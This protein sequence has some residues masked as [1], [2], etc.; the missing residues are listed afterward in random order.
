MLIMYVWDMLYR[1]GT[2]VLTS[3]NMS[4]HVWMSCPPTAWPTLIFSMVLPSLSLVQLPHA[5]SSEGS[6]ELQPFAL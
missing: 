2:S 1:A 5:P 4:G 3:G 6:L